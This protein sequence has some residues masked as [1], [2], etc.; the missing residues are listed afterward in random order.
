MHIFYRTHKFKEIPPSGFPISILVFNLGLNFKMLKQT[1]HNSKSER[2]QWMRRTHFP[3]LKRKLMREISEKVNRALCPGLR[4]KVLSLGSRW[5][6][7]GTSVP[8]KLP[9]EYADRG[10]IKAW[11]V[12]ANFPSLWP[13]TWSE[14]P[15]DGERFIWLADSEAWWPHTSWLE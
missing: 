9:Q 8:H 13:N 4:F 1:L 7:P 6:T 11:S 14:S 3:R 5:A 2:T 12:S 15:H 10:L